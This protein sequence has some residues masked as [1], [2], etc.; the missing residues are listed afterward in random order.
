M[1]TYRE[2]LSEP[3]YFVMVTIIVG[4]Q[5]HN[6]RAKDKTMACRDHSVIDFDSYKYDDTGGAILASR[7]LTDLT[8]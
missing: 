1:N 8:S 2:R 5:I 4:K 7:S 6:L 3:A